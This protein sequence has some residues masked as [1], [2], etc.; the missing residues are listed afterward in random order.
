MPSR[1]ISHDIV[2]RPLRYG[3]HVAF[4]N[5][6]IKPPKFDI[7]YIVMPEKDHIILRYEGLY[8]LVENKYGHKYA[9]YGKDVALLEEAA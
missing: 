6:G 8:V 9:R 2:G 1:I 3:D 5:K 7:G 4:T